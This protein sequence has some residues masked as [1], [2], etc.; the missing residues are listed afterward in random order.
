MTTPITNTDIY[1]TAILER[2]GSY[3]GRFVY[4]VRST[5]IFCRPS[6]PSRRPGR[7]Q[8]ELFDDAH[9]ARQA[10][11]RACLR[12]QPE[13]QTH[14]QAALVAEI[15]MALDE[16]CESI[17]SLEA[18]GQRFAM[19]PTHLQRVFRRVMGISPKR[20]AQSRR[21]ERLKAELREG[22]DVTNAL[23]A[24]GYTSSSRLYEQAHEQL[25]MTPGSYSRGGKGARMNYT[26]SDSPLGRLLVAATEQGVAFV[27]MG[28]QDQELEQALRAEYPAATIALD[29]NILQQWV[30]QVVAHLEGHE[31]H[32]DLPLD[33]RASAFQQQVWQALRS[34]PSGQTRSY[35]AIAEAIGK[36]GAARAVGQACGSN[37]VA[38]IIPC[39]RAVGAHAKGGG[40]RWGMQ[41]KQQ[42]LQ[43]EASGEAA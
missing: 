32:L 4:A 33:I 3:D 9:S 12:C 15:C 43:Q 28:D 30:N 16:D 1:W 36:P 31:P 39:H 42:L 38:L 34:I 13:A 23:Y 25:G 10:G 37:P 18:L 22:Q 21:L 41:R 6:C 35:G 26:I 14:P 27:A 29:Q 20:Y 2:D 8:V 7:E 5:G 19:S 24:A 17:P 11:F 40:Y